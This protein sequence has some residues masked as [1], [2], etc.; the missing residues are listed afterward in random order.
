MRRADL[1]EIF[2]GGPEDREGEGG[3]EDLTAQDEGPVDRDKPAKEERRREEDDQREPEWSDD[4]VVAPHVERSESE[5]GEG[6]GEGGPA[7]EPGGGDEHRQGSEPGEPPDRM[8]AGSE[9][10]CD[11]GDK[12]GDYRDNE[13]LRL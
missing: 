11:R 4:A 7:R 5:G 2:K 13:L 10:P 3:T 8:E 9:E 6:D 1:V 12:E